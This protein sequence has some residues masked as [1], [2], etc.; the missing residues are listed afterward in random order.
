MGQTI[1]DF[2]KKSHGDILSQGSLYFAED[3]EK[4][5]GAIIDYYYH[6]YLSIFGLF[7]FSYY[8]SDYI[9][10]SNNPEWDYE[11][12]SKTIQDIKIH[13]VA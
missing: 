13:K 7:S 4:L 10:D 6:L 9:G 11:F 5:M 2:V 8:L 3:F 12:Y 1:L